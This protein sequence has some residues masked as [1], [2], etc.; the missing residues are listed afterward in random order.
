M[1]RA[2]DWL[3]ELESIG[4][5]WRPNG[6]PFEKK[7]RWFISRNVHTPH[8]LGIEEVQSP[9]VVSLTVS[10]HGAH[11]IKWTS[12]FRRTHAK[13]IQRIELHPG[14]IIGLSQG[15]FRSITPPVH[16]R[17]QATWVTSRLA[18]N[19]GTIQMCYF[20]G[21]PTVKLKTRRWV[22]KSWTSIKGNS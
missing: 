8:K 9:R 18:Y 16:I 21:K 19:I 1:Q 6:H 14:K 5:S 7:P 2:P 13:D 22:I 11:T 12:P 15:D 17:N 3:V 20:S 4:H 10:T